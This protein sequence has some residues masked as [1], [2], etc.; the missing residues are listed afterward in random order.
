MRQ[1]SGRLR[2]VLTQY[3]VAGS[4]G[5]NGYY[6]NTGFNE[7]C[8]IF[9]CDGDNAFTGTYRYRFLPA[10]AKIVPPV[11]AYAD[12]AYVREPLKLLLALNGA[13]KPISNVMEDVLYV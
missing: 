6:S 5:V 2:P 11:V 8:I 13:G 10:L 1:E 9:S 3:G 7:G 12:N 4:G